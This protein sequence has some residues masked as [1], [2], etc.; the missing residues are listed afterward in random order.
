MGKAGRGLTD[1]DHQC[2]NPRGRGGYVCVANRGALAAMQR[3]RER[4]GR[5]AHLASALLTRGG[6]T[7]VCQPSSLARVNE[8]DSSAQNTRR[9]SRHWLGTKVT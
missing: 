6:C 3:E 9:H 1:G 4:A 2:G 8:R 5:A 7:G